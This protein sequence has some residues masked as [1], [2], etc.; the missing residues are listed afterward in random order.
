MPF[1][2]YKKRVIYG[3]AKYVFRKCF[4]IW[5]FTYLFT[6]GKLK[7]ISSTQDFERCT[8]LTQDENYIFAVQEIGD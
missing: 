2:F 1:K 6:N 3:K 8:Y 5:I 7:Y 4:E